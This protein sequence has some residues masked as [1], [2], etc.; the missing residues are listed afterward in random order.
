VHELGAEEGVG[1][2]KDFDQAKSLYE[3]F[4]RYAPQRIGHLGVTIPKHAYV[5][6][7]ALEVLYQSGKVDP[8]TLKLPK[9]PVNYIHEHDGGVICCRV[10]AKGG[11][12]RVEVPQ[13]IREA[14]GLVKLGKCLGFAYEHDDGR[15]DAEARAPFPALYAVPSGRALLVVEGGKRVLAMMW[16]GSLDVRPEGIVG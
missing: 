7:R 9:K 12:E 6:G 4:H 8:D 10:D 2:K 15:V 3:R 16:G 13:E 11:G 14:G 5:V 1:V